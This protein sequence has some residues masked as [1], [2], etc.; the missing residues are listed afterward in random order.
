[1]KTLRLLDA[2][3]E[4]YDLF[5]VSQDVNGDGK[6]DVTHCNQSVNHVCGRLGYE[7]FKG[8]VANQ[9]IDFMR[10][11]DDWKKIELEDAQSFANEGRLVIAGAMAEPHGHV[12]I[13][14]PGLEELSAKWNSKKVPKASHVGAN[15]CIGKS[16]AWAFKDIPELWV[17]NEIP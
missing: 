9:I 10:R 15:S 6:A 13:I 4:A 1:M 8:M 5:H 7:K 17:K 2:I 14:R 11:S 16:L 12:V 3:L